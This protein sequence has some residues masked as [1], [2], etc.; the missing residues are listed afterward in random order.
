MVFRM[1]ARMYVTNKS[2][3]ATG[4]DRPLGFQEVEASEFLDSWHM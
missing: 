2:F 4:L 3:P 1:G